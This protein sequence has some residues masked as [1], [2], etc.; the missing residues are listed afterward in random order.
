M[1]GRDQSLYRERARDFEAQALRL[2]ARSSLVSNLRGLSFG[3]AAVSAVAA[4]AGASLAWSL[5]VGALAVLSFAVL[6]VVHAR[7]IDAHDLAERWVDV[8]RAAL[9][10]LGHD[11]DAIPDAGDDLSPQT[12]PYARDLDLFGRGSLF[13]RLSV[14]RTRFGREQLA[15]FLVSPPDLERARRR[16]AAVRVLSEDLHF[17]QSFEA[18]A[19]GVVGTR[20]RGTE[21]AR[22]RRPP[23]P[24]PLLRW[25]ESQ[26]VLSRDSILR[27]GAVLLPPLGFIC[28]FGYFM[29]AL[30]GLFP[31]AVVGLQA[32]ILLRSATQSSRVFSAVSSDEGAFLRYGTLLALIEESSHDDPLLRELRTRLDSPIGKPS[33]SMAR[34][35]RLVGFFDLKHN[36]LVHPFVNLLTLWD[37]N[38]TLGLERWQTQVGKNLRGWFEVIGLY[39]GLA[40]LGSFA[41]DEPGTCYPELLDGP[42][43][44]ES[45]GLAHPLLSPER[46]V[47]NDVVLAGPGR[48]LLITGS[49][50]SGKSTLLRAMGLS[51]VLALAGAPVT[52]ARLRLSLL[53]V[54][55][56]M[57]VDDSLSQGVSHFFAEITR[58]REVVEASRGEPPVL[59]LLDEILHGTNSRERQIGARWVLSELIQHGAL[60]AVSTHDQELCRLTGELTERVRLV[61]MRES[62]ADGAMTFDYKLYPGAVRSGNALRLMRLIGLEVPLEEPDSPV[63]R[64]ETPGS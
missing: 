55:S 26:P 36:G 15:S 21:A 27:L 37:L 48:A 44:F 47:E 56:S 57:R 17:C 62:V 28:L 54:Q 5:P 4:A 34:F 41:A 59:F 52:A 13:Q 19:L 29:G 35:E 25:A 31:L 38:C 32:L 46:R 50:M 20:R 49:N 60:G 43:R 7:V 3:A 42:A 39:E 8:N 45:Q 33:A 9:A 58:L 11:F 24:E 30:S 63:E 64:K 12:H 2:E 22:V 18:H 53:R 10:R 14:A 23:N 40:S 51:T 61:H 16:Q 1:T 6:L